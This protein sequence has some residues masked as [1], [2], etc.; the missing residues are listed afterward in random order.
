[1]LLKK[2]KEKFPAITW[3]GIKLLNN[4]A[5]DIIKVITS[6]ESKWISLKEAAEKVVNQKR[7]Y[8]GSV[9]GVGLPVIKIV[10]IPLSKNFLLILGLTAAAAPTNASIQKKNLW[11][12]DD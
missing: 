3:L 8:L 12:R 7:G 1:M 4:D 11:I 6:L 10:P 5:K 9:M 2:N